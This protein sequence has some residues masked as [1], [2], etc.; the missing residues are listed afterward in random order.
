M[1]IPRPSTNHSSSIR[2]YLAHRPIAVPQ[3]EYTSPTD[4][5]QSS[6]GIYMSGAAHT[7][8]RTSRTSAV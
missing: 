5:S 6:I 8:I 1:N 3:H 7:P 4:Q 2:I